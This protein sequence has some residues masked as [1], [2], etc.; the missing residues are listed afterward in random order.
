M[1]IG[2]KIPDFTLPDQNGQAVRALDL[3]AKGP[4]VFY[5]YPKD[6]TLG[7]TAQACAFRDAIEDFRELDA[8]VVGISSDSPE[9]HKQF[10][11]R[12]RLPFTLLSDR[13]GKVRKQFEVP[14]SFLGLA[15]GRVTYIVDDQGIVRHIYNSQIN[16]TGHIGQA[17]KALKKTN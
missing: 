8:Q 9:S 2:D 1:N 14:K 4:V 12:H 5:F 15:P 11:A 6:E 3:C 16:T 10:A 7:C 17:L 13:G